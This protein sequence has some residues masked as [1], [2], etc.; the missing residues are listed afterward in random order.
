MYGHR[1]SRKVLIGLLVVADLFAGS[2]FCRHWFREEEPRLYLSRSQVRDVSDTELWQREDIYRHKG[3]TVCRLSDDRW[4]NKTADVLL[5]VD[6]L[7]VCRGYRGTLASLQ[8]LFRIRKVVLD[9]SLSDYRLNS[10][11][12]ECESLGLEYA[13]LSTEG[14]YQYLPVW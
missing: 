7:Y 12:E 2:V 10:L 5:D 8:Q 6:Y 9:A 4:Q 13:D 11:K 14:A 1:R 3:I